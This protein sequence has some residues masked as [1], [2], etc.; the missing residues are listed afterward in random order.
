MSYKKSMLVLLLIVALC[1]MGLIA[2][3]ISENDQRT[4]NEN[5]ETLSIA[6][7]F[8]DYPASAS[9]TSIEASGLD[10]SEAAEASQYAYAF[11][12]SRNSGTN[13][14]AETY[15]IVSLP[16]QGDVQGDGSDCYTLWTYNMNTG[17][18]IEV[19]T[20]HYLPTE[21]HLDS[22]LIKS[23][24]DYYVVNGDSVRLIYSK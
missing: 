8:E 21:V 19:G 1:L 14:L 16:C 9:N 22:R 23:G 12:D 10:F 7:R 3:F 11:T 6:P 2:Y 18:I 15:R 4:D 20:N 5:T 17:H 24:N 13:V